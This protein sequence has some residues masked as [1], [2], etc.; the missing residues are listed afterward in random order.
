M[1]ATQTANA[2]DV[3][4]VKAGRYV[5]PSGTWEHAFNPTNS[6][7]AL[8]PIV[9]RSEPRLAAVVAPVDYPTNRTMAFGIQSRNYITID[10]F[11]GEG[12]IGVMAN[13]GGVIQNC[14]VIYGSIQDTDNS[15]NWGI[16]AHTSSQVTIR[17]NYVHNMHDSTNNSHNTA[18]IMNL[19][20]SNCTFENNDVDCGGG[21]VYSAYGQKGGQITNCVWRYNIARN[22]TTGFLSMG[23]T[24]NVNFSTDNQ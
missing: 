16:T 3:V 14:E 9:F 13:T 11:K 4:I 7:T 8:A 20:S 15:L 24:N 2:G 23:S 1:K 6:G 22:G 10:G 5:D 17:N 21:I 19:T 18:G 12:E